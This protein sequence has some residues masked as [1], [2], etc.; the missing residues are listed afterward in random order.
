MTF[1][2]APFNQALRQEDQPGQGEAQTGT[3]SDS[4]SSSTKYSKADTRRIISPVALAMLSKF[5][6]PVSGGSGV[7]RLVRA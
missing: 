3:A 1:L 4:T 7:V 2:R 5:G 6:A